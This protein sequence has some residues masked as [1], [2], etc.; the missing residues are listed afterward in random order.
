MFK[1]Y[2]IGLYL[3]CCCCWMWQILCRYFTA[4]NRLNFIPFFNIHIYVSKSRNTFFS[5][6]CSF[7]YVVHNLAN[8]LLLSTIRRIFLFFSFLYAK[9]FFKII[10]TKTTVYFNVYDPAS[11]RAR[12]LVTVALY[13]TYYLSACHAR[14][15]VLYMLIA[16]STSSSSSSTI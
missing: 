6:L 14:K 16:L 1:V 11:E 2:Y 3:C 13:C 5:K 9:I 8:L 15:Q 10:D 7:E 12:T 4:S